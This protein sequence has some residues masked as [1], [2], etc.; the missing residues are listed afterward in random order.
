MRSFLETLKA[1]LNA[2]FTP[3][4]NF[5]SKWAVNVSDTQV[6][7]TRPTGHVESLNGDDLNTVVI[8]TT[9]AG[10]YAADVFWYLVG[11]QTGCV[12]PLGATGEDEMVK[13]FQALPGFDN[14]A[15]SEAMT[16]TSNRKFIVWQR[17]GAA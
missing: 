14:E 7:C 6:S 10:P 12:V 9:N 5:E 4:L 3:D 16:S 13:R 11:E 8:E 1:R 2:A 17:N 15:F